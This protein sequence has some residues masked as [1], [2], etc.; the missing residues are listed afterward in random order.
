[1]GALLISIV[2]K[3][4]NTG[5]H[6]TQ[7]YHLRLIYKCVI[8]PALEASNRLKP[9]LFVNN[10]CYKEV[11]HISTIKVHLRNYKSIRK[12]VIYFEIQDHL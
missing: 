5:C 2:H 3:Y 7:P 8:K 12:L 1:M 11:V 6:G 9:P 10:F 4:N